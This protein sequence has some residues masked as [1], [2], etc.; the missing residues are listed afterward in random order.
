MLEIW[1]AED[2]VGDHSDRVRWADEEAMLTQDHVTV[3]EGRQ[4]DRGYKLSWFSQDPPRHECEISYIRHS[5][6][7]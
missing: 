1:D 2:V 4:T 5:K 6:R 7:Y 3:L